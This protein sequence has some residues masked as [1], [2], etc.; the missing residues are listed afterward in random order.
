MI[1]IV[2]MNYVCADERQSFEEWFQDSQLSVNECFENPESK[3]DVETSLQRLTVSRMDETCMTPVWCT[4]HLKMD[5]FLTL[6]LVCGRL[7]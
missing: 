6:S 7:S 4:K 2:I 5:G 1:V 3:A